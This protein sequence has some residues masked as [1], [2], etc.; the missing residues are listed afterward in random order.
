MSLSDE[1]LPR[2]ARPVV[3]ILASICIL[4]GMGMRIPV[5]VDA[6]AETVA[7]REVQLM[8]A[9]ITQKLMEIEGKLDLVLKR[10]ASP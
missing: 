6:Q 8:E 4:I 7:K 1:W 9:R 5:W 2:K 3:G 10:T